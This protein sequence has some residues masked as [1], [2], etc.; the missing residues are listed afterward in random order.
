MLG[1]EWEKDEHQGFAEQPRKG[2]REEVVQDSS[3]SNT[4]NLNRAL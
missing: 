2:S 4:T 1:E 3:N